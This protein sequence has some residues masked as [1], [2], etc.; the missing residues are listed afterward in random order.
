MNISEICKRL[1]AEAKGNLI[2]SRQEGKDFI[3][4]KHFLLKFDELP[5]QILVTLFGIYYRL[6]AVGET[7][8]LQCGAEINASK[9][10]FSK[11]YSPDK[12]TEK[13]YVTNYI[14]EMDEKLSLRAIKVEDRHIYVNNVYV[15]MASSNCKV[16]SSKGMQPPIYLKHELGDLIILPYRFSAE[17]GVL[18]ELEGIINDQTQ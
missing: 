13:G 8:A 15:K 2:W 1:K 14:Y 12:Q 10:D 18:L 5:R 3:T 4:N 6:P 7:I 16:E 11:V 9:V 17:E